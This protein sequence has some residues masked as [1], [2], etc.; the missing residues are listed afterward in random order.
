MSYEGRKSAVGRVHLGLIFTLKWI[1]PKDPIP[2]EGEN[3]I[4]KGFC[5]PAL[6]A[7]NNQFEL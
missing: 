4:A 1:D 6:I 5:A 3:L 2:T 7:K